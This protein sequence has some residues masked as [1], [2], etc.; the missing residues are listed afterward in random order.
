MRPLRRPFSALLLTLLVSLAA[1]LLWIGLDL[2]PRLRAQAR[3]DLERRAR[4]VAA[5][6]GD[7]TFSDSLAD[8]LGRIAGV[9]V[10]LIDREGAVRG[11]SE[12]PARRIPRVENHAARPEVRA[13]LGGRAAAAVR[14]SRTVSLRLLYVAVPAPGGVVRVA[15]PLDRIGGPATIGRQ[16]ILAIGLGAV[17]LL[18]IARRPLGRLWEENA[19]RSAGAATEVGGGMS[20]GDAR[21]RGELQALFD[22]LD[23]GL[24]VVDRDGIIRRA[25]RTFRAWIGRERFADTSVGSLFRDPGNR[26]AVQRAIRGEPDEHE[27]RVGARTVLLSAR[28]HGE[29]ALV[30]LRDLTRMR[31]LESV[32]RDFV[33]NVSHEL[34]TPLASIRGFAEAVTQ[35]GASE[36][37]VAEFAGRIFANTTRMQNLVDDLLDLSRIESGAWTPH[38]VPVDLAALAAETWRALAA[39]PEGADVVLRTRVDENAEVH[40]DP[41]ALRQILRNL[42]DNALRYAPG[43]SGVEVRASRVPGG[44][45]IEVRDAGP[46]IPGAHVRRVFERFYRVDA[47]RSRAAGGTGLGLSI[48]KHLV[49]AHGG[50]V[51]IDSELGEGTTV[52]LTLPTPS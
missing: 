10:T 43:G 38:A 12:V 2:R 30:L 42:L 9:R 41:D 18:L 24:A 21:E 20:A 50:E 7:R 5:V 13:A 45:R 32:R 22:E 33:A 25:N 29:G 40:A 28:P 3:A 35:G 44:S 19:D 26:E 6:I 23:D 49:A 31:R 17:L 15:E 37:Q 8:R 52:W 11:D 47:A 34:K 46:G 51:G 4:L 27:S 36:E 14:P 1:S 16:W 48:V 39:G